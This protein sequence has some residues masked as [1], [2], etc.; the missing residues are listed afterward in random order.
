MSNVYLGSM[1]APSRPG[2]SRYSFTDSNGYRVGPVIEARNPEDARAK[3]EGLTG[4]RPAHC[5]HLS[6]YH[7]I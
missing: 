3:V 6:S 4:L 2:M 7:R 1:E 5:S